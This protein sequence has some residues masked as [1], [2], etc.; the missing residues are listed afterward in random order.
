MDGPC[1]FSSMSVC[2]LTLKHC[3]ISFVALEGHGGIPYCKCSF[4]IVYDMSCQ[5]SFRQLIAQSSA[6]TTLSYAFEMNGQ[7]H[8]SRWSTRDLRKAQHRVFLD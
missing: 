3:H 2:Q 5:V 4:Y 7:N 8:T 6:G 1:P